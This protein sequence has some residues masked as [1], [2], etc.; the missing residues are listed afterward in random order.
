M[1]LAEEERVDLMRY[2][3]NQ[4]LLG[5]TVLVQERASRRRHRTSAVVDDVAL[6]TAFKPK[7]HV[8]EMRRP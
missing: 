4:G 3:K 8:E 6:T 2:L 5:W 7:M 1:I